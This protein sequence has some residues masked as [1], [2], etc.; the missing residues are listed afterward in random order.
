MNILKHG[1]K[2]V[3]V[4]LMALSMSAGFSGLAFAQTPGEPAL[5]VTPNPAIL[6][7]SASSP[8]YDSFAVVVSG[9]DL[10][11]G[12]TYVVSDNIACTVDTLNGQTAIA[13]N[14]RRVS[15]SANESGCVPGVYTVALRT[16]TALGS[17]VASATLTVLG[18]QSGTPST[19]TPPST[20]TPTPPPTLSPTPPPT[21]FPGQFNGQFNGTTTPGQFTGLSLAQFG[22]VPEGANETRPTGFAGRPTGFAGHPGGYSHHRGGHPGH[23]GGR[24]HRDSD[25]LLLELLE[26]FIR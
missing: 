4:G 3:S 8:T 7:S 24:S 1:S 19:E 14:N 15:F 13:S 23:H 6:D 10:I 17:Q 16:P 26:V 22:E 2:V 5:L 12:T 18:P 20:G 25:T 21:P 11:P 9:T